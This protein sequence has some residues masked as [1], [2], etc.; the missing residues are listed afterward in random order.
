MKKLTITFAVVIAL[1]SALPSIASAGTF[2]VGN[3][4]IE[5]P[6]SRATSKMA[7]T[8]AAFMTIK[9]SGTAADRF[10]SA[11]S[12]ISRTAGL[13]ETTITDTI[14][15]MK[16][17]DAIEVP[18]GGTAMLKP[19]GYHIMF[20][21]L[22]SQLKAGSTFPLTLVFEKAGKIDVAV[23]VMKAGAMGGMKMKMKMDR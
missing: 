4:A 1:T 5:N 23:T 13:H 6:W 10:V 2:K 20:M 22:K 16:P 15:Q 17:V 21:G 19:G 8:G 18:A 9:N 7:K 14:M 3:I 12:P 11:S